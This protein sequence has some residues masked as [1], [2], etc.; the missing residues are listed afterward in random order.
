MPDSASVPAKVTVTSVLFHPF[1]FGSGKALAEATGRVLS[2]LTLTDAE[3]VNPAAF[4]AVQVSVVPPVSSVSVTGPHPVEEITPDSGSLTFHA[5]TGKDVSVP[6]VPIVAYTLAP[7]KITAPA[8]VRPVPVI[9]A[10]T[11]LQ[12]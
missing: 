7:L 12:D 1:A 4:T 11:W 6:P 2:I 5:I 9:V 3:L 8:P 10:L